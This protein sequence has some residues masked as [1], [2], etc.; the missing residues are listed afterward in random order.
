MPDSLRSRPCTVASSDRH[1]WSLFHYPGAMTNAE[2]IDRDLVQSMKAGDAVK[3]ATLRLLKTAMKNAE[4]AKR[5]ALTNDEI[6]VEIRRQV[7]MRREAISEYQ[8]A[9][10]TTQAEQEAS[11][12][13]ILERYLPQQLG[14]DEVRATLER[15]IA[16]TRASG[17][18]D[19]GKVMSQA[20][21][22]FKGQADGTQVNRV[23]RELLSRLGV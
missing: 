4:V 3:V 21:R 20:M 8:R 18:G 22:A 13:Q 16:E 10:R 19:L 1:V 11:E 2:Q 14:E 17:P 6:G 5:G 12:L 23:A 7:K 9:G 15:I